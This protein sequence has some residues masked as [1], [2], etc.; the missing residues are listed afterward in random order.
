MTFR[1][2]ATAIA[3]FLLDFA[4]KALVRHLMPGQSSLPVIRGVLYLTHV[5][6]PGAAF[7]LLANQTGLFIVITLAVVALI[8]YYARQ[9]KGASPWMHIALGLQ[10]G[11]AM[12]NL[13]DRLRFGRVT[14]FLDFRVWPVFNLADSAIVAGVALF[15]WLMW[16]QAGA[17]SE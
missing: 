4:T 8:L 14:D 9:V 6:N 17:E 16:R 13:V 5:R 3:V 10:L 7:G 12:G 2:A 1:V 15:F 11:G